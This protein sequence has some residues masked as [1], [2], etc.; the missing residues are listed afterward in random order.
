MVPGQDLRWI[1][2]LMLLKDPDGHE[3]LVARCDVLKSLANPIARKLIVYNDAKDAFDDLTPLENREPLAPAGH[4]LRHTD[5]GVEYFYF[6]SPYPLLRVR[7]D[8]QSVQTPSAYEG[9]TCLAPGTRYKKDNPTIDRDPTG[10]I[11]WAWKLNTPPINPQEQDRLVKSGQ[12][13][14]EEIWNPLRDAETKQPVLAHAASVNYNPFRKKFVMITVQIGGKSSLLGEV[15]FTES[16]HP[17]GP[18][19]W[20]RKIVTH[21]KYTFYNPVHHPFFDQAD[22][23]LIYFEGTYCNTFSGNPDQTPRYDYNQIMYR[24]DLADPRLQLP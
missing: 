3:R 2:G 21:D 16:D 23:R 20:A 13:K 7:A 1:D 5:A 4:P 8:W 19:T 15:Y 12:L 22:G 6:P 18:Y 11:I 10:K 17:E 9:F 14:S 24:L